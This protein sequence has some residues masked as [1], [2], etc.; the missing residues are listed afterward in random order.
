MNG[1]N[2]AQNAEREGRSPFIDGYFSRRL[3]SGDTPDYGYPKNH[4]PDPG[5]F[6]VE[7]TNGFLSTMNSG[8][9]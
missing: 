3:A 2:G 8:D 5:T 1:I 4:L 6:E 9:K 7:V